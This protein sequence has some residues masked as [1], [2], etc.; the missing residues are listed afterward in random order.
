MTGA[1]FYGV[2]IDM[3]QRCNNPKNARYADYGGRGIKVCQRWDSFENFKADMFPRP[4]GASLGRIDNNGPYS[5]Q[6]CRW[7]TRSQQQRNRR[8]TKLIEWK[9]T[10]RTAAE[11]A[12]CLKINTN[13]FRGRLRKWPLHKV[14]TYEYRPR[15]KPS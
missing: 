13:S 10:R 11:W 7:E 6:N 1:R 14:M 5:P 15:S 3:R 8:D 9:G 2:W 4:V 12:E